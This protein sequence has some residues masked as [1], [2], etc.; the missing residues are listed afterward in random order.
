MHNAK[1]MKRLMER[2]GEENWI[3][4]DASIQLVP[5]ASL[6][7][8]E[9][10]QPPQPA[11]PGITLDMPGAVASDSIPDFDTPAVAVVSTPEDVSD[12]QVLV[13]EEGEECRES[14]LKSILAQQKFAFGEK[15]IVVARTLNRLGEI[16]LDEQ[17]LAE[18]EEYFN[19]AMQILK[20]AAEDNP[21]IK[22]I[23]TNLTRVLQN[24]GDLQK[25]IVELQAAQKTIREMDLKKSLYQVWDQVTSGL[26]KS[27]KSKPSK[28]E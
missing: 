17:N 8:T 10:P 5:L 27:E 11:V 3:E 13:C 26:E 20:D 15:D 9:A 25:A 23:K 12:L 7:E 21:E 6:L 24:R 14:V 4:D 2:T 16:M 22:R 19:E 1:A 18:S 28:K